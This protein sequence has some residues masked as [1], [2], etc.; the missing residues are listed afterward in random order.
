MLSKKIEKELNN[1]IG[2][3]GESSFAYLACASWCDSNGYEGAASFLYRHSEE[4]RD[5][6]LRLFN[7]INDAG[8]H[9]LVPDIKGIKNEYKSLQSIFE[10]VLEHEKAVTNAI[11]KMVDTCMKEKDF[12]TLNFLQWYV[13]E[14]H[15]EE[16]LFNKVLD[17]FRLI[18]EDEKGLFWIDKELGEMAAAMPAAGQDA[19]QQ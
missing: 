19:A 16:A 6:M 7:Y 4:E 5:H 10:G 15:E 1:Q 9:A 2:M 8:G 14:Q 13:A 3:E 12:S 17:K 18:G 11:N